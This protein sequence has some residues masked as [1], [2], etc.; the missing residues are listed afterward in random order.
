[1]A[2]PPRPSE[3]EVQAEVQTCYNHEDDELALSCIKELAAELRGQADV[4]APRVV[5]LTRDG[6]APCAEEKRLRQDDIASGAIEVVEIT[7]PRGAA[8]A[9]KNEIDWTP[10]VLVLDCHEAVIE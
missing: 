1:M 9:Q 6:C 2:L 10:A 4:C 3:L 5:M 7:T 8:I